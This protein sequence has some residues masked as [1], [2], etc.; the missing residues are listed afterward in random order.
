VDQTQIGLVPLLGDTDD[1][2]LADFV[3]DVTVLGTWSDAA[4]FL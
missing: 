1:D 4:L 2:G 3:V